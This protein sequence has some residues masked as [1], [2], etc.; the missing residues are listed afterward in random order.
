MQ[1]IPTQLNLKAKERKS[2]VDECTGC[3][4]HGI[5]LFMSILA[6]ENTVVM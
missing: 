6:H 3:P 5:S 2:R 1:K 4:M